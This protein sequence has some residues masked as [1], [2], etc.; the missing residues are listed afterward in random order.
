MLVVIPIS[1]DV[2]C[3]LGKLP[4][5]PEPITKSVVVFTPTGWEM[6]ETIMLQCIRLKS[7]LEL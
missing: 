5:T 1:K 7:T 4:S 6:G 3:G 2:G